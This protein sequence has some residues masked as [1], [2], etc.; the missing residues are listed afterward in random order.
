MN[1]K[2]NAILAI[3]FIFSL[4]AAQSA[5]TVVLCNLIDDKS[6]ENCKGGTTSSLACVLSYTIDDE[7]QQ[8]KQ[9]NYGRVLPEF[10]VRTWNANVLDLIRVIE[11]YDSEID[12]H[13]STYFDRVTGG[14]LQSSRYVNRK[15]GAD[16]SPKD[17]NEYEEAC[18]KQMGMFG[19]L[20]KSSIMG[21]CKLAKRAF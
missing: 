16:I 6:V 13:L 17:L 10:S 4:D 5:E 14:M 3:L 7:K 18:V 9:I 20:D 11:M 8:V 21:E 12:Q 2:T 1:T 19:Y 15:T